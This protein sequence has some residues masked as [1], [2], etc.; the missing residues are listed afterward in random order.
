M[1][2]IDLLSDA[3]LNKRLAKSRCF[4]KKAKSKQRFKAPSTASFL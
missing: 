1:K 4:L 2:K 3:I